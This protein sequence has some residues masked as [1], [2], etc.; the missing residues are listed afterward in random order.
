MILYKLSWNDW[1][2]GMYTRCFD[3][4]EERTKFIE[5]IKRTDKKPAK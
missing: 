1:N 3:T 5:R 2:G 4:E